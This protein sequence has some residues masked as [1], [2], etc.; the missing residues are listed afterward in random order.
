M[1]TVY[2]QESGIALKGD[3]RNL[4]NISSIVSMSKKR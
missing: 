2:N 4:N 1:G 3:A